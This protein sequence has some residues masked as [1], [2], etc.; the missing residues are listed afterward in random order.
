MRPLQE[1]DQIFALQTT[2]GVDGVYAVDDSLVAQD[3]EA[4][5]LLVALRT[6][7]Q[8]IITAAHYR[9]LDAANGE[10]PHRVL[11]FDMARP[12]HVLGRAT[13]VVLTNEERETAAFRAADR[14]VLHMLR[15][16]IRPEPDPFR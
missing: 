11:F 12:P 13:L 14:S 15:A 1:L 2:E 10:Q 7:S 3:R 9:M 16:S 8:R 4:Y 6:Y 5:R